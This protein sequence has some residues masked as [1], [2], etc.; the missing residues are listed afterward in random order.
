MAWRNLGLV[1][2]STFYKIHIVKFDL[3]ERSWGSTRRSRCFWLEIERL[4]L[5]FNRW[6]FPLKLINLKW[7]SCDKNAWRNL[8]FV[9]ISSASRRSRWSILTF[10]NAPGV[11]QIGPGGFDSKFWVFGKLLTDEFT[12]QNGH[13]FRF[14]DFGRKIH[15][16]KIRHSL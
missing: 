2:I 1:N 12:L 5:V 9:S 16:L 4:W 3:Y 7:P 13:Y 6:T 14:S 11:V 15:L 10:M 8:S